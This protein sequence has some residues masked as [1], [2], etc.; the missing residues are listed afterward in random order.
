MPIR[1]NNIYVYF[2]SKNAS[3]I[4]FYVSINEYE[5]MSDVLQLEN[6]VL[7]CTHTVERGQEE[8]VAIEFSTFDVHQLNICICGYFGSS[9]GISISD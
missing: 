2:A 8:N 6:Y 4:L 9:S 5:I 7:M 1:I 3:G